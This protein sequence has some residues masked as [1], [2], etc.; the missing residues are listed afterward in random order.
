[1]RVPFPL[2][3]FGVFASAWVVA[4]LAH[5]VAIVAGWETPARV[6][7]LPPSHCDQEVY[8]IVRQPHTLTDAEDVAPQSDFN[9][10]VMPGTVFASPLI[11]E[12]CDGYVTVSSAMNE[13]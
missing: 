4:E 5:Q 8:F 6:T 11:I 2:A 1:M 10:H 13:P 9:I 12:N 3:C 7:S